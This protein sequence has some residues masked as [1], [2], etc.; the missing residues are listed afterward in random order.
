[1]TITNDH[2]LQTAVKQAGIL[3]QQIQDYCASVD[4]RWE[5]VPEARVRFPRGF[6]RTASYQKLRVPFINDRA[7]KD[8]L[9]YTLI[10]SDAVLWLRIRTDISGTASEMLVKLSV[11]LVGTLCE[12]I[13][14]NYLCG[15]CGKPYKERNA[16]LVKAR[17]IS[18]EL[19]TELNWVWDMRNNMHLFLLERR[20]YEN[21]Y[22]SAC[23]KRC[24]KAF[25]GLIAALRAAAS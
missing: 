8:N 25:R 5:E 20:E 22:N 19:A 9:A 16:Y 10:L 11:F 2:E 6:I 24:I 14:K 23:H 15:K 7:L 12:S 4:K 1:M 18:A 3:L 13:T 21:Q 17:I